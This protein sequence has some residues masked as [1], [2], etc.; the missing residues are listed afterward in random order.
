MA[1]A[2]QSRIHI[3]DV[4]VMSGDKAP[5]LDHSIFAFKIS[6]G[7]PEKGSQGWFKLQT[8]IDTL[9]SKATAA[10][11]AAEAAKV[12][13]LAAQE[14]AE[15]AKESA[16]SSA[17]TASAKRD[18]AVSSAG[19]AAA[20]ESAA[21]EAEANVEA[22]LTSVT[23]EAAEALSDIGTAK[24]TAIDD[25]EEAG[26]SLNLGLV[27]D[28]NNTAQQLQDTLEGSIGEME[29]IEGSVSVMLS[30]IQALKAQIEALSQSKVVAPAMVEGTEMGITLT[31]HGG[32]PYLALSEITTNEEETA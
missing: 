14:A 23:A 28:L 7:V 1:E 16:E 11:E 27:E 31:V 25:I 13:A 6:N 10:Q 32:S 17:S 9:C 29:S 21:K 20:S 26:N 2:D 22:A 3:D 18:E 30:Q 12:A 15:T 8:L 4:M 24:T 19:A 5:S